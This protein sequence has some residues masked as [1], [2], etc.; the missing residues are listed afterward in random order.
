MPGGVLIACGAAF[1]QGEVDHGAQAERGGEEMFSRKGLGGGREQAVMIPVQLS[2]ALEDKR[3]RLVE[4]WPEEEE[5]ERLMDASEAGGVVEGLHLSLEILELREPLQ[6]G[7]QML[8]GEPGPRRR[9]A[10]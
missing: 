6:S 7:P 5:G 1:L 10:R 9:F 8:R 3:L 4:D 2:G